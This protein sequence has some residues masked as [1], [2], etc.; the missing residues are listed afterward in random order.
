MNAE[1]LKTLLEYSAQGGQ[2]AVIVVLS[3]CIRYL[4]NEK[5]QLLNTIAKKEDQIYEMRGEITEVA[6]SSVHAVKS[7]SDK[8]ENNKCNWTDHS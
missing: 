8:L 4:L 6:T 1:T 5:K 2:T 7:I 3:F